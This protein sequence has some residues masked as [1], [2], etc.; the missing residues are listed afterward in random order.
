MPKAKDWL[1]LRFG[2][3]VVVDYVPANKRAVMVRCDCGVVKQTGRCGLSTKHTLSCGCLSREMLKKRASRSW[4]QKLWSRLISSGECRNWSGSTNQGGYGTLGIG[5]GKSG[6][7]HR[8]AWELVNGPIPDGMFV[9]HKCDNRL[10]CNVDHL[11]LGDND[12]NMKDMAEKGRGRSRP[13]HYNS[14]SK[15]TMEQVRDI[16]R[17]YA[18]RKCSQQEL[19]D[20][21][22]VSQRAISLIVR[23]ETYLESPKLPSTLLRN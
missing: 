3:L 2:R 8:K 15:L 5:Q 1:G 6:L 4:D 16:R 11:F 10:C 19:A 13:G 14:N 17:R 9:L 21:Y 18:P 20:E 7:A 12:A 23:G 22:G